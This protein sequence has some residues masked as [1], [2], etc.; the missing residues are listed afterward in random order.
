M[1]WLHAVGARS[2]TGSLLTSGPGRGP[3]EHLPHILVAGRGEPVVDR[4]LGLS[5]KR[6]GGLCVGIDPILEDLPPHLGS[7]LDAA[8][9]Y[10]FELIEATASFACAFKPNCAFFEA[11][12][13]S[14]WDLLGEVVQVAGRHGLVVVDGKRGDVG[15]TAEA[16]AHAAF[17]QL[18]A[19]ACTVNG[20]VGF[21]A[22][23][24][25]IE[26]P[27]KL[28][29]VVCRTSNPHAGDLQDLKV[30]GTETPLYLELARLARGWNVEVGLRS[31]GLVAG[32]TWPE[33]ISRIRRAAPELPLLIPGVGSQGGDLELAVSAALGESGEG[34]YLL[35]VSRAIGGASRGA[36]FQAAAA[37]SAAGYLARLRRL[38][39]SRGA[40]RTDVSPSSL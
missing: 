31:V 10:C 5:G 30:S 27:D 12:G 1:P 9:R 4:L 21:D 34:S 32:A 3:D 6:G 28:A 26:R 39:G 35:S 16:Y 8:R 20:Y 19:D 37:T 13:A 33:E 38:H 11:M 17:D 40:L 7:G 23:A 15:H 29:F 14:G 25:F 22:V 36:D 18:E 2:H 24:P